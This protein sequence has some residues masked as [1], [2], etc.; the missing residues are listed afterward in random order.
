MRKG[1]RMTK[2]EV[3]V[4]GGTGMLG[5]MVCEVLSREDDLSVRAS[6]RRA[7]RAEEVSSRLPN[8][9]CCVLDALR[10]DES[11]LRET[12]GDAHWVVNAIGLT[13][14]HIHDDN[15][16]EVERAIRV[17]SLFPH[18][19]ARA[20]QGS[21]AHVI[22]IATDCVFSGSTGRYTEDAKHDALDAYGKT[23]SLGEV[24]SD[25]MHHL[26]TS[27]I[28]PEPKEHKFLL[29]WL[30]DQPRGAQLNGFVNHRWNGVTTLQFARLCLGIIRSDLPLPHLHH[31]VPSGSV[32]KHELLQCFA[33]A[34]G[35]TDL[36]ITPVEAPH[37][38]DRTLA[39]ANDELNRRLWEAAGY[40]QAPSVPEMVEELAR[41]PY[42]FGG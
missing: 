19:L 11:G 18:L 16:G 41:F 33:R 37:V 10:A 32:S 6:V 42:R 5:S 3:L 36:R 14:P 30:L 17:N 7:E 15:A 24:A 23:K 9:D 2:K 25:H 27:I 4:L 8:V 20:A 34:Y 31:A 28:G 1:G 39:T 21:G 12:L 38:V 29:H 22:Q 35:R 40:E 13:K 26:R